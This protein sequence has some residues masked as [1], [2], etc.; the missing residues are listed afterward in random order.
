MFEHLSTRSCKEIDPLELP[1]VTDM[2]LM[3]EKGVRGGICDS[4]NTYA[5]ANNKYMEDFD[6]NKDSSY[7]KYWD[8][9]NLYGWEMSHYHQ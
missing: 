5:A 9:N 7:P 2:S 4:I 1:S 3:V 8:V 6:K